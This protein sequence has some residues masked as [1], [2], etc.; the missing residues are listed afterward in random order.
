MPE[1]QLPAIEDSYRV[2]NIHKDMPGVLSR[3]NG[4][5]A[6]MSV[7]IKAQSYNTRGGIGYLIMDV[8]RSLSLA[9]QKQI[10]AL[11]SSLRTRLLF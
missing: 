4:L 2:L 1:V 5:V 7:N 9:V 6:A 11:D 10:E 3:I 8:E